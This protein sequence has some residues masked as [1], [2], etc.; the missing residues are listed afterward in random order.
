ML[1][2]LNA[3]W[4]QSSGVNDGAML[5]LAG[6][7]FVVVMTAVTWGNWQKYTPKGFFFFSAVFLVCMPVGVASALHATTP[8]S[9]PRVQLTGRLASILKHGQGKSSYYTFAVLL[10][11]GAERSFNEAATV[12]HSAMDQMIVVTY[13]DEHKPNQFA[14]AIGIRVLSGPSAGW[15]DSVSADWLGPWLGIPCSVLAGIVLL[16]FAN[17]NLRARPKSSSAPATDDLIDLGIN[18]KSE[19]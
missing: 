3:C 7:F 10:E 18:S 14:R 19:K 1:P 15:Q 2:A 6:L 8:S 12:P 4:I 13:L 5:V 11:D 16:I 17:K 9:A